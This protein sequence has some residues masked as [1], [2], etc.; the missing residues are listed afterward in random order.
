MALLG[1]AAWGCSP[2]RYRESADE[3]T[4]RIIREKEQ[5]VLG[6][7]ANFTIERQPL[8]D[9]IRGIE[10]GQITQTVAEER[11]ILAE[12]FEREI[13]TMSDE[14]LEAVDKQLEALLKLPR[15]EIAELIIPTPPNA[16][17]LTL[18]QTVELAVANSRE[19][20][21]QKETLFLRALA[22]TYQRHLWRPQLGLTTSGAW[23]REASEESGSAGGKFSLG[24]TIASGAK[25]ALNLGTDFLE[26]FTGDRRRAIGSLLSLTFTQPLLKGG[27]RLVA[28]ESLTQAERNVIYDVRQFARYRRSFSVQVAQSYFGV[29]QQ[30]DTLINNFRNY[31]SLR[32]GSIRN[33]EMQKAGQ[34]TM[35]N[36]LEA[37]EYELRAK[38]SWIFAR[39][40][41]S[42]RLDQFKISPLG[43]PTE[44]LIVLDEKELEILRQKAEGGLATPEL[45]VEQA[46]EQA[47][48][49][50]LDLMNAE[51][52]VG[53]S[54]RAVA[55]AR[56]ALRAILDISVS[57]SA[58]T[59]PP[60]KA[61][62]F[63]F[64]E[65][66]YSAGVTADLPID[67]KQER[68]AYRQALIGLESQKRSLSLLRDNIKLQVRQAYR[69]LEQARK[70]YEIQKMSVE[71]AE[72]RVDNAKMEHNLGR[73]TTRDVLLAEE[74]LLTA[75]NEL[76]SALVGH[77]I[78]RLQLLLSTESLEVDERGLWFEEQTSARGEQNG[79]GKDRVVAE[80]EER[81]KS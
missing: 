59:E 36:L 26:F 43:L 3:E 41:Y 30:R 66:S 7:V 79:E 54:E 18:A 72:I 42:D 5:A 80:K 37:R 69:N 61:V 24:Q 56:D 65:G 81:Q 29:V 38:N 64:D 12:L 49:E 71:L 4:Y 48:A 33:K 55:I 62:K 8:P 67:R 13:E 34:A 52:A 10:P 6:E 39:Q 68:N 17:K 51:D 78:A 1:I 15:E 40:T 53:D 16:M 2:A 32:R 63:L 21:T 46:A 31:I 77:E 70:S 19:F 76:T 35:L 50:R 60:T 25:V 73:A 44:A 23:K 20:Q 9:F 57:G 45:G 28:M 14:Q 58:K 27:G 11:P 75:Q 47:L 74:A 22:L